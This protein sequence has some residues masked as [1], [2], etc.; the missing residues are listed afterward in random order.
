MPY[1]NA[2]I[3]EKLSQEKIEI[4]K[5][6]T[7]KL[8]GLIGKSETHL[9]MDIQD[10]KTMY[11]KGKK[12][13]CAYIDVRVYGNLELEGKDKFVGALCVVLEKLLNIKK[14]NVFITFLEF[15]NWGMNGSL[16]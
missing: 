1:I 5:S 12:E 15:K 16:V 13:S 9:M 8:L 6:E 7:G 14:E 3:T 4:L 10:G 2:S 11:F